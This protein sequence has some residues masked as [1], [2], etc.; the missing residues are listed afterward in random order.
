MVP[1]GMPTHTAVD[2]SRLPAPDIIEALSYEQIFSEMLAHLRELDAQFTAL[3]ESDP[4]YKIIQV[5][6]YRELALRQRVNESARACMLAYALGAD[7][8]N[9][10]ALL[11]V[12][13]YTLSPG[14]PDEGIAPT[15]ESDVDFRRRIQLAPEGFS[16]AGPE[17]AYIF[18]ALSASPDVLDAS[19]S[20][21]IPG[22]VVVSVLSRIGDGTAS[23]ELIDAVVRKLSASNV[24]PLTDSLFV[25][26]AEIVDYSVAAG[27][28][29]FEGPDS[30]VVIAESR[31]RLGRH[32]ESARRLGRDITRSSIYA[33]LHAEGVQRVELTLP[34]TDFA[35]SASQA[36]HCTS[37]DVMHAGTDE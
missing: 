31:A 36:S 1:V 37:I 24:R 23:P 27:I 7:L 5:C 28:Y 35:I 30:S 20:S 18:H 8:D 9:L 16:V 4:L 26:S 6:A 17:G 15:Y 2:L 13:R 33:A 34:A 32:I 19:V 14:N 29:T 21:P 10:G 11:G 12:A 22:E 3:V 25:Q